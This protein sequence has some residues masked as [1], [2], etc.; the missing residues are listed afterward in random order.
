[1]CTAASITKSGHM[2]HSHHAAF[3]F[4]FVL[5]LYLLFD[6]PVNSLWQKSSNLLMLHPL[7]WKKKVIRTPQN[8]SKLFY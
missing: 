5:F 8:F 6:L 7:L 3:H 4:Q 1:M 2:Q